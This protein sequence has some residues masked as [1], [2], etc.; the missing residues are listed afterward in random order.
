MCDGIGTLKDMEGD[1]Y[2]QDTLLFWLLLE[3]LKKTT[4]NIKIAC[5]RLRFKPVKSW[6]QSVERYRYV[7]LSC[8]G[9]M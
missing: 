7:K 6:I 8:P 2:S 5:V 4:K 9:T 3:R 1:G